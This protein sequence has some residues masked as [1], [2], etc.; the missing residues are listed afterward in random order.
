MVLEWFQLTSVG[1]H[2][3]TTCRSDESFKNT[4]ESPN[5]FTDFV[6]GLR[7]VSFV[8]LFKLSCLA[9]IWCYSSSHF[10]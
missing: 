10:N 8:T 4:F 7:F 5:V 3:G 1:V 6:P 2:Q 9:F